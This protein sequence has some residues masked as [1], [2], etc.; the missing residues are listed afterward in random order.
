MKKI[1]Q[2]FIY[3]TGLIALA[4]A[5]CG[6]SKGSKI[7]SPGTYALTVTSVNPVSGVPLTVSPVDVDGAGASG[8]STPNTGLSLIY[9]AGTAV[10]VTANAAS[11][12]GSPFVAWVGC[13]SV[14]D[15]DCKVTMSKSKNVQVQYAGVSSI[16]INPATISVTAGAGVQVPYTV[17]GYGMC[18]DETAQTPQSVPCAGSPVTFSLYL[19]AG[20]TGSLGTISP[21]GFYTPDPTSPA[22]SVNV[23]A[24]SSIAPNVTAVGLIELQQ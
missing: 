10:T 23:T 17:N 13:D 14:T 7:A 16:V 4:A 19:P 3:A 24:Q 1:S 12:A 5:G 8:A 22:S 6:G 21:T 11:P 20:V 9:S 15:Y 2:Q 18:T